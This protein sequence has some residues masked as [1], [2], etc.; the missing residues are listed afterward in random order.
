MSI[1]KTG[2]FCSFRLGANVVEGMSEWTF[3]HNTEV[4]QIAEWTGTEQPAWDKSV[5]TGQSWKATVNGF[6]VPDGTQTK[7]IIDA[8]LNDTLI[9]DVRLYYDTTNYLHPD[10]V[11]DADAGAKIANPKIEGRFK[12]VVKLSFELSGFGPY[13]YTEL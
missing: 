7:L 8:A 1:P 4:V 6:F 11:A 13:T 5:L 9:Q 10:T 3:E 2:R 12:D